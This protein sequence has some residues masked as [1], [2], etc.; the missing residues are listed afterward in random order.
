LSFVGINKVGRYIYH[1]NEL[2][3]NLGY[4]DRST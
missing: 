1:E 2:S 3:D 4:I